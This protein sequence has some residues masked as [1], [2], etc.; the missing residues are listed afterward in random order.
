MAAIEAR[1]IFERGYELWPTETFTNGVPDPNNP[2]HFDIV[3]IRGLALSDIADRTGSPTQR[4]HLR[5]GLL[6]DFTRLLEQLRGPHPLFER[7]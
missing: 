7:P 5:S 2:V 1:T 3:V 6:S 4:R